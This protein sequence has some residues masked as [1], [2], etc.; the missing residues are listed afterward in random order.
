MKKF[1]LSLTGFICIQ[2]SSILETAKIESVTP[3]GLWADTHNLPYLDSSTNQFVLEL[4]HNHLAVFKA[5]EKH[6]VSLAELVAF[7]ANNYLGL[8]LVPPTVLRSNVNI[9][10]V[11]KSGYLQPWIQP[12]YEKK[13]SSSN[14]LREKIS[15]QQ[16]SQMQIFYFL[17]G[18][19]DRHFGNQIVYN[20]NGE[21]K[22]AL[23]DNSSLQ[24]R[25]WVSA[26]GQ[27][28]WVA[29]AKAKKTENEAATLEESL[30]TLQNPQE[31]FKQFP[32]FDYYTNREISHGFGHIWGGYLWRQFYATSTNLEPAFSKT[33]EAGLLEKIES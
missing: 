17:M 12:V 3:L 9:Q 15:S 6:N 23:I 24:A 28:P 16:Y 2:A 25:Q 27:L 7:N 22:L 5:N 32:D 33:I 21:L 19:Y 31:I 1:I 13:P 14:E 11:L 4:G 20:D 8:D 26:Y 29:M 18:Q 10:G 30:K